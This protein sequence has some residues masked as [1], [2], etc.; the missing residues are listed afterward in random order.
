[1]GAFLHKERQMQLHCSLCL[2]M[3][4][5]T[6]LVPTSESFCGLTQ[7]S[8]IGTISF[9]SQKEVLTSL[10]LATILCPLDGNDRQAESQNIKPK[11]SQ[12]CT[13]IAFSCTLIAWQSTLS[14]FDQLFVLGCNTAYFLICNILLDIFQQVKN[15]FICINQNTNN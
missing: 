2:A 8:V 15:L 6:Q 13:F 11:K 12:L 1:M 7:Q 3:L 9:S 10:A 4:P 14:A 5:Q